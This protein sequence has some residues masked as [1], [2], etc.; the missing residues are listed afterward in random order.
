MLVLGIN[1]DNQSK[2]LFF[3]L[4]IEMSSSSSTATALPLLG[5]KYLA[6]LGTRANENLVSD[7]SSFARRQMEKM[8]WKDGKGLGK[9]EQGIS[10]FVRINKREELTG[11]SFFFS[12][13]SQHLFLVEN[14]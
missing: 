10:T 7:V 1:L 6:T 5:K 12:F 2:Q 11:V 4:I 14:E 8:G 9:Q 3:L 13:K